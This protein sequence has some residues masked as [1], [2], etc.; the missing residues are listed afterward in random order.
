[1]QL[2]PQRGVTAQR[3]CVCGRAMTLNSRSCSRTEQVLVMDGV[4]QRTQQEGADAVGQDC[5]AALDFTAG[6]GQ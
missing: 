4:D 3:C 6:S 2:R 1:M 5:Q